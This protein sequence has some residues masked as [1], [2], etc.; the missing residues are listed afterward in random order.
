M[1]YDNRQIVLDMLKCFD[2]RKSADEIVAFFAEDA[3]YHNMPVAPIQGKARIRE[4]FQAFLDLMDVSI[5]EVVNSAAN[6]DVV[7]TERIDR[8]RLRSNQKSFRFG[9]NGVFEVK[10]GKITAFRD[11]FNLSDFEEASG[12]KL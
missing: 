8:F 9:V 1:T 11:Y 6:G 2:D 7:F 4:I 12:M 3:V 10:Q 5:L